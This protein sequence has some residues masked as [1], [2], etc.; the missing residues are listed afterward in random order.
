M[1]ELDEPLIIL[2]EKPDDMPFNC[3]ICHGPMVAT[4]HWMVNRWIHTTV[5]VKCA[6]VF[7]ASRSGT[8]KGEDSVTDV[9]ERFQIFNHGQFWDKNAIAEAH[10]FLP[11]SQLKTLAMIG[12][13]GLGK[14]RLMWAVIQQFSDQMRLDQGY[15]IQVKYFIFADVLSDFDRNKIL[16]IKQAK[17]AFI[18]D[19]GAVDSH[20]QQRAQLQQVIRARIQ[21]GLWTFLT[22]DNE[23]FD[24]GMRDV[25]K[26]RAKVI[27]IR[28]Q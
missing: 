1:N 10:D 13:S 21:T 19:I 12:D 22:I 17:Y 11:D 6:E 3:M 18:D 7:D 25:L 23:D 20:G 9:P 15:Q 28:G 24:P 16:A 2:L 5:H 8:I 4:F 27:F 14:S 26:G